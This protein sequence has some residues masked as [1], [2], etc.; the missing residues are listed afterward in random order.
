MYAREREFPA[1]LEVKISERGPDLS[2]FDIGPADQSHIPV[3]KQVARRFPFADDE[4]GQRVA[5]M[6]REQSPDIEI[7]E[8]VHIVHEKGFVPVEE[9]PRV[10]DPASRFPQHIPFIGDVHTRARPVGKSIAS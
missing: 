7:R 1:G 8:N 5:A 6:G 4:R 9:R 3:K 2:C 10:G